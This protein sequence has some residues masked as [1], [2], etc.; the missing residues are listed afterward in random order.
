VFP[1]GLKKLDLEYNNITGETFSDLILPE[2][3]EELSLKRNRIFTFGP[4][5]T[6]ADVLSD[7]KLPSTLKKLDLESNQIQHIKNLEIPDSLIELNLKENKLSQ[8]TKNQITRQFVNRKG[9]KLK[10]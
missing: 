10:L 2:G 5:I 4:D 7:L 9:F 8:K 3:L 1:A 6:R